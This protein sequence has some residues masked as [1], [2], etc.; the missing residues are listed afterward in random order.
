LCGK[1]DFRRGRGDG[2]EKRG[3]RGEK[4]TADSLVYFPAC[5]IQTWREEK[6]TVLHLLPYAA[7]TRTVV[8]RETAYP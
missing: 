7:Q 8:R 5:G 3:G 4:K 6:G 2:K 1:A